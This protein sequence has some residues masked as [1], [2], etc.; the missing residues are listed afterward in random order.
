MKRATLLITYRSPV[1]TISIHALVK[2]A[3]LSKIGLF[4]VKSISIHAL[5]KRATLRTKFY[6]N[7]A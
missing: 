2:R 6:S 4:F 5:V 3:T 7:I 1:V